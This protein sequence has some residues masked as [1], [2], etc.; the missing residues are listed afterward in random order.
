M[1]MEICEAVSHTLHVICE[2]TKKFHQEQRHCCCIQFDW[3]RRQPGRHRHEDMICPLWQK[4]LYLQS[5]IVYARLLAAQDNMPP[6][7]LLTAEF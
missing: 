7:P 1:F 3:H 6:M 2:G 5:Q 4:L